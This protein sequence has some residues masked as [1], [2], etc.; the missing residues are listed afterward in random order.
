MHPKNT[1]GIDLVS[2]PNSRISAVLSGTV[3]FAG[4]TLDTGYVIYIQHDKQSY[5]LL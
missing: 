4:W 1:M 3:L 5:L 2:Q